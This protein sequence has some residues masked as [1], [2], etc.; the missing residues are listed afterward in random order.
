MKIPASWKT[1]LAGIISFLL[2]AYQGSHD[3]TISGAIHDPQ[4]QTLVVVGLLGLLA[5]DFDVTG[6]TTGQPSTPA[7]MKEANQAPSVANPPAKP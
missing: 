1:A 3:L 2:A 4:F 5:K 7:A 6:G